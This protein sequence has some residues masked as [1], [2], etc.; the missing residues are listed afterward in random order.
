[1]HRFRPLFVQEYRYEGGVKLIFFG[2]KPSFSS[3]N[4]LRYFFPPFGPRLWEKPLR[5]LSSKKGSRRKNVRASGIKVDHFSNPLLFIC[6][7]NSKISDEL[8]AK[9]TIDAAL[10][11][12]KLKTCDCG[13]DRIN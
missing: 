9:K 2:G 4:F 13:A 3:V 8:F 11:K 10:E 7:L 1:M 5:T 12:M 6:I